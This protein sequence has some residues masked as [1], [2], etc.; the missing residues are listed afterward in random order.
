MQDAVEQIDK[1]L[2]RTFPNHPAMDEA[3][4]AAL[5]RVLTAYAAHNPVVGYCQGMNFLAGALPRSLHSCIL[6]AQKPDALRSVRTARLGCRLTA[7][8]AAMLGSVF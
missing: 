1:D 8:T 2:H 5:R 6:H 3:G 7:S 4:R